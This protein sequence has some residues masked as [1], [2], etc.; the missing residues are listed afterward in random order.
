MSRRRSTNPAR[1]REARTNL[2]ATAAA[3][4]LRVPAA[5]KMMREAVGLKQ[6]QFAQLFKLTTRQLSELENGK[7]NPTLETLNRIAAPFGF[8]VGFIPKDPGPKAEAVE[9]G[10]NTDTHVA[11]DDT[12]AHPS[13]GRRAGAL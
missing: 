11:S 2:A 10:A 3:A 1:L 7:G 12:S 6:D 9:T 4:G 13:D 5:F 8:V